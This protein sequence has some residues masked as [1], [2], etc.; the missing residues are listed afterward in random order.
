[1]AHI[2]QKDI[3]PQRT[4]TIGNVKTTNKIFFIITSL[5]NKIIFCDNFWLY[6]IIQNKS[7][8]QPIHMH[9]RVFCNINITVMFILH[10]TILIWVFANLEMI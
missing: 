1:M 9:Y 10:E 6:N 8:K 7:C 4:R 5:I 3:I 2:P